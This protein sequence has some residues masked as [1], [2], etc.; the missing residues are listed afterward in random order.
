MP[1]TMSYI[2]L[3]KGGKASNTIMIS[4]HGKY[5]DFVDCFQIKFGIDVGDKCGHEYI[6][7]MRTRNMSLEQA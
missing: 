1:S 4:E 5:R 6:A 7:R 3:T 2:Y